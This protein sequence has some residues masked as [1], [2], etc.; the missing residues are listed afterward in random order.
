MV[1]QGGGDSVLVYFG[2]VMDGYIICGKSIAIQVSTSNKLCM[3]GVRVKPDVKLGAWIV[4]G[5]RIDQWCISP[6]V[7]QDGMCVKRM[8]CRTRLLRLLMRAV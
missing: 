5:L 2:C 7:I 6:I 4:K 3:D 1:M 8:V